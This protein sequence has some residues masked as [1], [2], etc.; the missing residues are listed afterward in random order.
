M[1]LEFSARFAGQP[2]S[3]PEAA[4]AHT[5]ASNMASVIEQEAASLPP[6]RIKMD[7][8]EVA[9]VDARRLVVDRRN[10]QMFAS[11]RIG[12]G[13][14]LSSLK[15]ALRGHQERMDAFPNTDE[16]QWWKR[17]A[18]PSGVRMDSISGGLGGGWAL[19]YLTTAIRGQ[20]LEQPLPPLN[21]EALFTKYSGIGNGATQFSTRRTNERG[22]AVFSGSAVIDSAQIT[23]NQVEVISD[24]RYCSAGFRVSMQEMA[25][26]Q[27]GNFQL[28]DRLNR[29][30]LRAIQN[31]A[32][33]TVF[34][35]NADLNLWGCMANHP[36]MPITNLPAMLQS[37]YEAT[38]EVANVWYQNM[39]RAVAQ[40][41]TDNFNTFKPDSIGIS[42]K[43]RL[44]LDETFVT[45]GGTS[46]A[47]TVWEAFQKFCEKNF[48]I[49][50]SDIVD[51]QEMQDYVLEDATVVQGMFVYSQKGANVVNA[52]II[53]VPG[54]VAL[55]VQF[56]D[57][58]MQ[59]LYY[60]GIG[61]FRSENPGACNMVYVKVVQ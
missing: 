15:M 44:F 16:G 10:A 32:N 56:V 48:G 2:I 1:P 29:G 24:I 26:A 12:E 23:T 8:G 50:P 19:P 18:M 31:L 61:G 40:V 43:L 21:A 36:V 13:D 53:D 54:P 57:M 25:S 6:T 37:E 7:S 59:Q 39:T 3:N 22:M 45:L 34:Y 14:L 30:A 46:V 41:M 49:K 27:F 33:Y 9:T 51:A 4:Q 52:Q 5:W 20:V 60:K 28:Q 11:M 58:N 55:P 42:A 47:V 17:F 35:G 38:P